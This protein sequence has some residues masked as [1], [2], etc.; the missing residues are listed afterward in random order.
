VNETLLNYDV[1]TP[2]LVRIF[3]D[4]NML[5]E[6][7]NQVVLYSEALTLVGQYADSAKVGASVLRMVSP[8][9]RASA[10]PCSGASVSCDPDVGGGHN[11]L[12]AALTLAVARTVSKNE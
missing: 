11:P 12:R 8:P 7:F 1:L 10:P 2:V 9:R 3:D 4:P 6:W 5:R